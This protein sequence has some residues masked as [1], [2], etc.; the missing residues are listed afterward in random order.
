M[1]RWPFVVL[2]VAFF[3]F[4]AVACQ[5]GL[6]KWETWRRANV[7]YEWK[8][9]CGGGALG[10][11]DPRN[12]RVCLD[13]PGLA[14]IDRRTGE[15]ITDWTIQHEAAHRLDHL[16]GFPVF[17]AECPKGC[18]EAIKFRAFERGAECIVQLVRPDT[19]RARFASGVALDAYWSCP[20]A[21]FDR[22]IPMLKYAG[23]L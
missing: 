6:S 5:A 17:Q 20:Q 21:W 23:V 10:R 15:A 14:A 16:L 2:I 11:Y 9:S 4:V 18:T 12:G 22:Y 1:K 13:R 8:D 3:V 19:A 7:V